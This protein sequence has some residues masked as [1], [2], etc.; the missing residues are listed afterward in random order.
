MNIKDTELKI[1]QDDIIEL[2][3]EAIV[4]TANTQLTMAQGLAGAIKSKGGNAIE[5]EAVTKA[6]IE[7]GQA[8]STKGGDLKA[9]YIIHAATMGGDHQTDE[10]K[11]RSACAN[12]LNC[13]EELR[14]R[15]IALPALGCGVGDFPIVGA[16]K[17]MTQEVL[18]F[19]KR[20][21]IAIREIIFCLFDDDTYKIFHETVTGY[22]NHVQTILGEEPYVTVDAIIEV[23]DGIVLIERSNPPYG[24]ALPGGFLDP[25]ESL[26]D[27]VVREA[28]E[29]TGLDFVNVRQFHTYSKLG[30]DPRFHT[31]STVFIGRGEG[32]PQ[33]G[34]DAKGLK[35][36]KHEDLL[37]REYAFDHKEIITDYL[38]GRGGL[39]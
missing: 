13:A 28:K 24:W 35:I 25:G 33:F 8:V 1:V 22:V 23:D 26:E 14:V 9:Q 15:S 38:S 36:V 19:A 31:I 30:R 18:K 7:V 4:N 34:D 6:P 5:E 11:I 32:T 12:A 2:D 21:G 39:I 20:D 27:A 29:E 37:K 17:I 16:A 10:Q 3:V